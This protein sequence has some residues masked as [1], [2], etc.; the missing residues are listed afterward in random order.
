MRKQSSSPVTFYTIGVV[1]LFLAG[2]FLLVVFGAQTYRKVASGQNENNQ[3]R[4]LLSYLSTCVRAGDGAGT[5]EIREGISGGS[6]QMLV[7]ADGDSGY[8]IK[9]Y[10]ENGSLL[11][12]YGLI[13]EEPDS[14][15]AQEIGKTEV[16]QIKELS[17]GTFTITTDA[18]RVLCHV[19]GQQAAG[20]MADE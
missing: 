11:E 17:E 7:V 1:I 3:S 5:I 20:G 13:D 9:I 15:M 14:S 12:E 18:G 10:P 19:R 6:S 2:F 16:F 4:A 8:A